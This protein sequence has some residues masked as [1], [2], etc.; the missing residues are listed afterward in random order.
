MKETLLKNKVDKTTKDSL[1]EINNKLSNIDKTLV[2]QAKELEHH[3]KRTNQL[4]NYIARNDL[5]LDG[6]VQSMKDDLSSILKLNNDMQRNNGKIIIK[7]MIVFGSIVS[8]LGSVL[9]ALIKIL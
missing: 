1:S 4:E 3:V 5:K 9:I 7:F 2:Y 6:L 8:V